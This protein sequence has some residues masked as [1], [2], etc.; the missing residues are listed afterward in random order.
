MI[1]ES[2]RERNALGHAAREMMRVRICKSFEADEPHEFMHFRFLLMQHSACN[3]TRFNI[4][5]NS[6]PWE[7]NWILKNEAAFGTRPDDSFVANKDLARIRK[8]QAG[9]ESK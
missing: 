4:P 7:P 5:A 1:D 3:E 9:D 8:I 6:Q 2:A